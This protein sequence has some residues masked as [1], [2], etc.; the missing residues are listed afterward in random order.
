MWLDN[1]LH[2]GSFEAQWGLFKLLYVG[3]RGLTAVKEVQPFQTEFCR[4][5]WSAASGGCCEQSPAARWQPRWSLWQTSTMVTHPSS[6]CLFITILTSYTYY[7]T[8]NTLCLGGLI[9][10]TLLQP[11]VEVNSCVCSQWL[12]CQLCS[13]LWLTAVW[14][15]PPTVIV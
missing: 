13:R 12:K 1:T 3:P 5:P 10:P 9:L 7:I 8:M 4:R 2:S 11:S 14:V 15:K 6:N